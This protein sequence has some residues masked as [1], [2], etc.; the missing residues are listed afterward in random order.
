MEYFCM[1]VANA[2]IASEA[3]PR[4][5]ALLLKVLGPAK[6]RPTMTMNREWLV[7]F[8]ELSQLSIPCTKCKTRVLLDATDQDARI[9]DECPACGAE[10]GEVFRSTLKLYRDVYR[11]LA[12]P[13]GHAV[14]VRIASAD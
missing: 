1:D 10:Y 7:D 4:I 9:P 3:A 12:D 2:R 8:K 11:R 6:A 14:Q 5:H 13:G